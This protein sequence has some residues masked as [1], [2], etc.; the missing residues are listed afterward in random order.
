MNDTIEL[1]NTTI[2]NYASTKELGDMLDEADEILLR[3]QF[4]E[5]D[6]KYALESFISCQEFCPWD[7]MKIESRK[8]KILRT[9][10]RLINI[11]KILKTQIDCISNTIES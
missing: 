2:Q 6:Y 8:K 11:N 10:K 1:K 3:R 9:Q 7:T 4:I 5:I